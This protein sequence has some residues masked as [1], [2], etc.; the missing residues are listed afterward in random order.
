MIIFKFGK[1]YKFS[2]EKAQFMCYPIIL[3]CRVK[4]P[5]S[6]MI[7]TWNAEKEKGGEGGVRFGQRGEKEVYAGAMEG[8]DKQKNKASSTCQKPHFIRKSGQ[9]D[10]NLRPLGPQPSALPSYAIPRNVLYYSR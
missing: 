1:Y 3:G 5:S 7:Q 2:V 6:T 8:R 4:N 10:L 9:Q